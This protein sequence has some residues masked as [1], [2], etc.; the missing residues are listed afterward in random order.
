MLPLCPPTGQEF[1]DDDEDTSEDPL[2][3]EELQPYTPAVDEKQPAPT[4]NIDFAG[5]RATEEVVKEVTESARAC[6]YYSVSR[7]V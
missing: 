2:E 4:L 6:S 1:P 3:E 5:G 7:Y